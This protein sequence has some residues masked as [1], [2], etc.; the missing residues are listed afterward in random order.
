M[1][2]PPF[3]ETTI[4]KLIMKAS[5]RGIPTTIIKTTGYTI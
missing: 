3:M 2:K 4:E 1:L 5:D